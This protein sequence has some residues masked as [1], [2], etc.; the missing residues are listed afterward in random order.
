[1][2]ESNVKFWGWDKKKRTML[3]FIKPGDIFCFQYDEKTYCFGRIMTKI[4]TGHVAEI[5]DYMCSEPILDEEKINNSS[6]LTQVIILD[7]Y[8]LFDRKSSGDWRIIGHEDN[9][10]PHDVEGIYFTYGVAASCKRMDI[11]SQNVTPISQSEK[12]KYIEV[13]PM[14]D[15]YVKKIIAEKIKSN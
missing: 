4:M 2:F 5:I 10:V 9:Y 1:M 11:F 13:S 14:G 3:R 7:S 8:G 6:R 12:S 15:M